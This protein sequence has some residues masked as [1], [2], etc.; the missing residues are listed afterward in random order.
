M[1]FNPK[2]ISLGE[3]NMN[4]TQIRITLRYKNNLY[5]NEIFTVKSFI[6]ISSF[7]LF[8]PLEIKCIV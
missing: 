3:L 5:G 4:A 1:F 7:D 8:T 2:I 6:I